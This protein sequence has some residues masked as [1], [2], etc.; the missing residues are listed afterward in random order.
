[1]FES[2]R[3]VTFVNVPLGLQRVRAISKAQVPGPL[4]V[5]S[6]LTGLT[7]LLTEKWIQKVKFYIQHYGYIY[8]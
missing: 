1:M 7:S 2:S 5:C 6:G 4:L 3:C 8:I